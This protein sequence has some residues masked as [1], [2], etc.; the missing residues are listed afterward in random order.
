MRSVAC[1]MVSVVRTPKITGFRESSETREESLGGGV[2]DV[3]VVVSFAA[4][5]CAE[6]DYGVGF[7]GWF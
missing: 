2:G 6:G 5:D 3:V 4:D 1:W 7:D